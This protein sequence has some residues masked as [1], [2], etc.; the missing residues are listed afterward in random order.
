MWRD[1]HLTTESVTAVYALTIIGTLAAAF[2]FFPVP[3]S[4][5]E[6]ITFALGAI[7]GALTMGGR[8]TADKIT[9]STGDNTTIQPETR[10]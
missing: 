8:K 3:L 4:N 6:L 5:K 1:F 7:A 2:V 10:E 9:N